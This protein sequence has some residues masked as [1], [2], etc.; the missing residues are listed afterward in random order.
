MSGSSPRPPDPITGFRFVVEIDGKDKAV[1]SECTLPNL[2]VDVHEQKEGG[3]NAGVHLLPGR[4]KAGR[5]TLKRGM[6][7]AH[8]LI[9]W[10]LKVATGDLKKVKQSLTI[11]MYDN[12][13][14]QAVWRLDVEGAFPVKWTGPQ[15]K[16]SD[17][18][19]A[20]ETLELAFEAL[21]LGK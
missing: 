16:A 4:V 14:K 3:F 10:Y 6:T 18:S 5:I 17:S 1:F 13:G 19:V 15:L 21:T 20:I 2:E 11:K 7:E 8:D 9:E 12:A